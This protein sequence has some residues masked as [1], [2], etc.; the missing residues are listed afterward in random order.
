MLML[1]V[2]GSGKG[3]RPMIQLTMSEKTAQVV[4][5]A[6]E[7]YARIRMGQFGEIIWNCAEHHFVDNYD[8]A[9][10]AWLELRKYI[11][12]DLHGVGHSYGIGKFEDADRAFDVYQVLRRQFGDWREP[13][14]LMDEL[15]TCEIIGDNEP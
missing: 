5:K 7:F 9:E 4:S 1:N 3:E 12:P 2:D 6:C 14:T 13:F 15:P 11:Y 8:E 10:Q